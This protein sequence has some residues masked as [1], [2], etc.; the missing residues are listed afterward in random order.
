MDRVR[1]IW[2]TVQ[3]NGGGLMAMPLRPMPFGFE[4]D[5]KLPHKI[6]IQKY[7]CSTKQVT[8]WRKELGLPYRYNN[9]AR[10]VNQYTL[11]GEF[12]ATHR[13]LHDAARSLGENKHWECVSSAAHGR[14]AQAYGFVWRF[15]DAD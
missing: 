10:Q 1:W 9:I 4:K 3:F 14:F 7:H 2:L 11:D 15:V 13:S 8:R 6:L 12:V 5:A